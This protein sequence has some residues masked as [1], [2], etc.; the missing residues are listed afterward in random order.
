MVFNSIGEMKQYVLGVMDDCALICANEMIEIMR[1]EIE[2]AYDSYSPSLY[3]RTGDLLN[4]PQIREA[5]NKRMVTEFMDNGG[6][7]SV[8][9][10]T[11][12]QHFFALEGLEY[13]TTW[14]RDK[15]NIVPF[16]MVKCYSEIP[17][18]Y[19]DC[20]KAFGIPII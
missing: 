1:Q 2:Q 7:Y 4:T 20:M 3:V 9:G 5:S 10:S 16:S 6:W 19:K 12:G 17:K 13:G 15:T 11:K 8:Q 14:G 18:T